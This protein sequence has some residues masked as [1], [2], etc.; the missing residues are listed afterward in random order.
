MAWETIAGLPVK[1]FAVPLLLGLLTNDSLL[2]K[3]IRFLSWKLID[4]SYW[5]ARDN[6][7]RCRAVALLDGWVTA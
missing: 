7:S 6:L 5:L 2:A 3:G 4:A 1:T